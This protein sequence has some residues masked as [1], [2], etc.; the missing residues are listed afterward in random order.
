MRLFFSSPLNWEDSLPNGT[1]D[2]G[3]DN[4]EEGRT[5]SSSC[6]FGDDGLP[7]AFDGHTP[8][9]CDSAANVCDGP[10]LRCFPQPVLGLNGLKQHP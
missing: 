6:R 3:I 1:Q 10:V 8:G 5:N 4:G 7:P 2:C 9:I